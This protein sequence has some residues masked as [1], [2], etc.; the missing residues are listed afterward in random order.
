[1]VAASA[2]GLT[3]TIEAAQ[4]RANAGDL[5]G[6]VLLLAGAGEAAEPHLAAI[7][8]AAAAAGRHADAA[9]ALRV[10]VAR[11]PTV[12]PLQYNLGRALAEIGETAEAAAA[13]RAALALDPTLRVAHLN[14]GNLLR[15]DG[16]LDE[17]AKHFRAHFNLKRRVQ[18]PDPRLDTFRL[19]TRP[20]LDHDIEQFRHLAAQG[21]HPRE[22]AACAAA[23]L[24]VRDE[25]AWPAGGGDG[26]VALTPAQM[27]RV[28]GFYN[29]AWHVESA[30]E[31]S[32]DVLGAGVDRAAILDRWAR[33]GPGIVAIDNLLSPRALSALRRFCLRSTI[34][35]DFKRNAGYLGAYLGDGIAAPL[36]IQISR[37]LRARLPELLGGHPLRQLWAYK[38]DSTLAGIGMHADF[39]AVNMNFWITPDE[40]NLDPA[41]GG[42]RVHPVEAPASW[43]FAD[44]NANPAK[45]RAFLADFPEQELVIPYR[46]NRAV[47]FNSDL[48]HATD[49]IRFRPGYENRRINVTML[50][51]DRRSAVPESAG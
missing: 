13:Y 41:S 21:I 33:S 47:L 10:L 43:D 17:A 20:K 8:Q 24:R 23:L 31:Q 6:A 2:S 5:A 37:A 38:Y 36:L 51:G 14:L 7:G 15:L 16:G 27:Q 40:A 26:R 45:I 19:T 48:F 30:P 50:F 9:L 28:S 25:I 39:A 32:G 4:L 11:R 34:W 3:A 18:P 12:A 49:T 44:Y 29:R 42:L 1:M 35:Y 22:A 46:A